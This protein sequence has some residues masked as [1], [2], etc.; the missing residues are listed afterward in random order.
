MNAA[1]ARKYK[2]PAWYWILVTWLHELKGELIAL[3]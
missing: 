2:D 3:W 1:L